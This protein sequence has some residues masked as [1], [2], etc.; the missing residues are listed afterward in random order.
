MEYRIVLES[1]EGPM[2][3]LLHLIDQA[4]IDIYD[5]PINQITEQYLD[6][7]KKMELIDLEI[8]SEFLLMAASLLE[9]KSKMLLPRETKVNNEGNGD[10]EIDPRME[11]VKRLLE[12]KKYK[13]ASQELQTYR[14]SQ[15]K[16][17]YKP[18]EDLTIFQQE[19]EFEEMDLAKL[20]KALED[21]LKESGNIELSMD[22]SEIQREE[23]TLN[24]SMEMI[25]FRLEKEENIE[26]TNLF[27]L[28]SNRR[29]IVTIFLSILELIRKKHISIY[30][31]ESFAEIIIRKRG[32]ENE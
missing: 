21:L 28:D 10:E 24:E 16:I 26:F 20:V 30:Q 31:E 18:K 32:M 29:E 1:F 17:Y 7:I 5:I 14:T 4:E 25:K 23:Y 15:N 3:L 12:Y 27:D 9:I 8:T 6:Y 19:E 2:D 22:V 13:G 11:L